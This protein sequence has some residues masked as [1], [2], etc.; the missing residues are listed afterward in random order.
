[1]KPEEL[2]GKL[3]DAGRSAGDAP[4]VGPRE[5]FVRAAATLE[6]A[7]TTSISVLESLRA[8]VRFGAGRVAAGETVAELD[9]VDA[10]GLLG[11][12]VAAHRILQMRFM[13]YQLALVKLV[14]KS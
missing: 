5:E 12:A 1:M 3:C 6:R 7:L 8:T 10:G 14:D 13:V 4:K 9:A 11:S 2:A